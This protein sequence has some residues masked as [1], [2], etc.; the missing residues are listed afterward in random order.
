METYDIE[1]FDR[2]KQTIRSPITNENEQETERKVRET[3]QA[4][5]DR[6]S[7]SEEITEERLKYID[8]IFEAIATL[9]T[10][11]QDAKFSEDDPETGED[12]QK[13]AIEQNAL[14]DLDKL[15]QLKQILT[16][17]IVDSIDDTYLLQL[18]RMDEKERQQG[19]KLLE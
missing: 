4:V 14:T 15:D 5:E 18:I 2:A 1:Q 10:D 16:D 6:Y 17:E 13:E 8:E 7:I 19:Q 11:K 9:E 12:R 3:V